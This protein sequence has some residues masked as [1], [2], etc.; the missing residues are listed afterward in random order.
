MKKQ[1]SANLTASQQAM[2]DLWEKHMRSEFEMKSVDDTLNTMVD[3]PYVNHIPVLTGGVDRDE[4]REFYSKRFIP[5][6]P[7]DTETTLI[8][9]TIGNDRLVDELIFKFTHTIEMEWMLPGIPPTG[10]RVEVPLVVVI[11]FQNG[12]IAH[13]HIY[14]DQASVL[15]QL[16]LIDDKTLPVAGIDSS[17]KVLDPTLSSNKLIERASRS[18]D[19][20]TP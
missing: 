13:E 11:Q 15:V 14:W 9:R 4:V 7:P 10:K 1:E 16:G 2:A 19:T 12:K 5:Q 8:S 6:I 3:D 20:I 18:S 17:R